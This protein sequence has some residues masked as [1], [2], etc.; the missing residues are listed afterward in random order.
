[1]SRGEEARNRLLRR[2]DFRYLLPDPSPATSMCL[3]PALAEPLAC[4]SATVLAG[5]GAVDAGVDLV[6][7]IDPRADA[8][9]RAR[10][11]LRPGGVLYTEWRRPRAETWKGIRRRLRSAGFEALGCWWPRPDPDRS[12]ATVWIPV[13]GAA[14]LR[15]Y[16]TR[17]TPSRNPVRRAARGARTVQWLLAPRRPVCAVA[18]KAESAP[19]GGRAE[20]P[21]ETIRESWSRWGLGP[22]PRRLYRLLLAPPGRSSGKV[23]TL[24]FADDDPEPRVALKRARTPESAEGLRR[25]ADVLR[26]LDGKL[27]GAGIPKLFESWADGSA[28]EGALTGLPIAAFLRRKSLEELADAACRWLIEFAAA[29]RGRAVNARDRALAVLSD[30]EEDYGTVVDRAMLR[31]TEEALRALGDL[32]EVCEQRD[33]SPWNVHWDARGKLV[34]FDWESAERRGLPA[35]DL[36][37]FLAFLGFYSDRALPRRA[38]AASFRR[39]LDPSSATGAVTRS[40]LARYAAATGVSE[41]ALRPLRLTT[42]ML[43]ARSE[44]LRLDADAGGKASPELLRRS[45]F[46]DLW[47]LEIRHGDGRRPG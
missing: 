39:Q 4:M 43:H 42:W 3:A 25:E 27:P 20:D 40:S 18:T 16:R 15:Y 46:R 22:A 11:A 6:A 9:A 41:G 7:A 30:F 33:F 26:S 21:V 8:L 24:L 14:P 31:E 17:R 35:L 36:V 32:S 38:H 1:M 23:V 37:Y 10:A 44:R 45:V 29:T 13:D 12:P 47:E 34:V 2:A 5:T 28:A 19:P